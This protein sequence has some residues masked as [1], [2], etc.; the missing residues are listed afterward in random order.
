MPR[1]FPRWI[2]RLACPAG[3]LPG[4]GYPHADTAGIVFPPMQRA[5]QAL[6]YDR[7]LGEIGPHMRA[8]AVHDNAPSVLGSISDEGRTVRERKPDRTGFQSRYWGKV[9]P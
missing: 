3:N 1:D 9:M 7:T 8:S 6:L 5:P 2:S 4:G